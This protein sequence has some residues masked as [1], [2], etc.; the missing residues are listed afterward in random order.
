MEVL[1]CRPT[2]FTVRYQINPWMEPQR[3]TDTDLAIRQWQDLHDVYV[4]LGHTV[5]LIDPLP[6]YPDMVYSANGATVI[7][8][9]AYSAKF[10]YLQR[11][12]EAPA[13]L[14]RLT[15]LGYTPKEATHI[16]EGEGDMLLT[17]RGILAGHGF[18]TGVAAH[19][20]L[21]ET[22]GIPVTS[23]KLVNPYYYHLDTALAVLTDDLIA[24]YPAAFSPAS[25]QVLTQIFPEAITV[26]DDDAHVLG[27]NSVSD[28]YNVVIASQAHGFA[29]Q[30][31]AVG[32]NP[33]PVNTSEVLKGGGG[34][35]CCT[36]ILRKD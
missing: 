18:R 2:Y 10:R 34:A 32:L 6:D 33:I 5:H 27:L 26:S 1:M 12:G 19:S 23:L 22:T 9:T 24:Y 28:G 31:R 20:E 14:A 13:Y 3:Y 15:E 35:K 17:A 30:V 36:L 21:Q 29:D 16:N 7:A 4:A 8:G 25:Q 11:V